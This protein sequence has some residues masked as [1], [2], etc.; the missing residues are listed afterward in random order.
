MAEFNFKRQGRLGGRFIAFLITLVLFPFALLSVRSQEPAPAESKSDS[1]GIN[2]AE[3]RQALLDLV[4]PWTVMCV[5]AHPDDEDGTTLTVLR[6][7]YGVHTVTLFSTYGEGG[8][9]AIG[10]ELYEELGVIREA[11]TRR[12]SAIQGS[13]PHFLGLRDFGFSKSADET[14]RFWNHDEALRRMVLKIR[15]LRPDAIIT[16]HDTTSGHGHHQATGRLVLEAFSS[17]ADP[18]KFPEQLSTVP[19]WQVKRLFVRARRT[20]AASSMP[21]EEAVVID[22]N[23]TDPVRGTTFGEQALAALQQHASQGPWPKSVGEWLRMQN[24]QS[25][26]LNLIRYRFVK[27]APEQSRFA[28]AYVPFVFGL[29]PSSVAIS[30]TLNN[31]GLSDLSLEPD[32]VLSAL[33]RWS[34][35]LSGKNSRKDDSTR[36]LR[37]KLDGALAIASGLSLSV[38]TASSLVPGRKTDVTVSLTNTGTSAFRVHSLSLNAWEQEQRLDAAEHLLADTETTTTVGVMTPE[39]AAITVPKAKHLY[40]G[41]LSGKTVRAAADLEFDGGVRFRVTAELNVDVAPVVEI[42]SVSPRTI[43]RTPASLK[44][45]V[46]LRV[47]LKNH[48]GENFV[49]ALK[50]TSPAFRIFEFGEQVS[51]AANE[52]QTV[53]LEA[54]ATLVDRVRRRNSAGP[55]TVSVEELN[56]NTRISSERIRIVRSNA[57]VRPN[58]RVGYI[59]S[60]DDSLE[61]ALT[62]LGVEAKSLTMEEV[63]GSDLNVYDTIIIDNRGYEAHPELVENNS[64]LLQFVSDGGTLLVFY[65][66]ESE[67]NPNPRRSR[68][69]L[70]PFP[71]VLG[72][73]RVTEEDAPIRFRMPSHRLLNYPNRINYGDFRDWVQERGLYYP[74]EWDPSYQMLFSANDTQEKPLYGGLLVTRYGKGNYIYTSMVW[75]RQLRAGHAGAFRMLAN[76]ISYVNK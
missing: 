51:L 16:N 35:D 29:A 38:S 20:S 8:Q 43:V 57:L 65:H 4:N 41:R 72:G 1:T 73:E 33:V 2:Q 64:R 66:R 10:P 67:W 7:K 47:Q 25:G 62:G 31:R 52:I 39:A 23:E 3:L 76:M 42:V 19:V 14:F 27:Q 22:P 37:A 26:K 5:A 24:N 55:T 21:P 36:S 45:P 74:K 18:Q 54:N 53:V 50:L 11:E 9:N 32:E 34:K 6:R 61:T 12:A 46:G 15:E 28:G 68:P 69:Q 58:L 30:P 13:E 71:I 75:Y 59:P 40:D 17:A 56:S 60:F 44:R 70:A 63:R 49:G 48:T